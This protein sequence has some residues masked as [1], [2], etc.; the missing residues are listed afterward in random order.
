MCKQQ[1]LGLILI[2]SKEILKTFFKVAPKRAALPYLGVIDV[3]PEL[4]NLG[5][6]LFSQLAGRLDD[7][8]ERGVGRAGLGRHTRT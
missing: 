1:L 4:L 8:G 2:F 5:V 7:Y 6:G 3:L